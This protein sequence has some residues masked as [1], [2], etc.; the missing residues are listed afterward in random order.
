MQFALLVLGSPWSQQAAATALR[1]A[2]AALDCGHRVQRVF[3]YHDGVYTGNALACPSPDTPDYPRQW[4]ALAAEH[5]IDLVVCI[6][7]AVKRGI[8]P[9]SEARR[10]KRDA[11]NLAPGFGASG[12]GQMAESLLTCDRVVTFGP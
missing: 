12:L 10:H 2:R 1:F 9:A 3:F 11:A 6:A 7:S 8:L 5:D 4:A